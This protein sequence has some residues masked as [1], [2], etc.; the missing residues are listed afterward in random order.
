MKFNENCSKGL[1]DME[2]TRKFYGWTDG[3]LDGPTNS[4]SRFT[5]GD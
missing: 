3:R 4:T 2:R 1:G 5:A